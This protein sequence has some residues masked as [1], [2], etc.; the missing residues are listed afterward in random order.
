MQL[1]IRCRSK[2]FNETQVVRH[3]AALDQSEGGKGGVPIAHD[4]EFFY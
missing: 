1:Y 3:F 4:T 2:V